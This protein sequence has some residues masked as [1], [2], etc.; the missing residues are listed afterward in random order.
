M[1]YVALP[2]PVSHVVR[3][4]PLLIL[5]RPLHHYFLPLI[6]SSNPW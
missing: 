4:G 2:T 3:R 6:L 5:L 1:T